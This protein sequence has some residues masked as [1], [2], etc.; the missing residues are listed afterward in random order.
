MNDIGFVTMEM[1][2]DYVFF[3]QMVFIFVA[4]TKNIKFIK[5]IPTAY[6]SF[7]VSYIML[8]TVNIYFNTFTYWSLFPYIFT[9]ALI[10]LG[11]NAQAMINEKKPAKK[12]V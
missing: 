9:A 2:K 8:V 3:V 4:F 11:S 1:F 7:G 12:T 10:S 5:D 6:Y